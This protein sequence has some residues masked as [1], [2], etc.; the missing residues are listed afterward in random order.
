MAEP[1]IRRCKTCGNPL[2]SYQLN[3][4][5][6]TC[7]G[8]QRRVR[9][10]KTCVGCG[11][12]F[13]VKPGEAKRTGRPFCSRDCALKRE[14]PIEEKFWAKVQ[15]TETCWLWIGTCNN[16][17]YG[18]TRLHNRYCLAHRASYELAYGPFAARLDVRH[19]C[20][21]PPCVNPEHLE[22]GTHLENMRDSVE[23]GRNARGEKQGAA[24]MTEVKVREARAIFAQGGITCAEV[25]SRY[26]VCPQTMGH[27]LRRS[28]WRHVA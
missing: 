6:R 13:T 4:C 19:K 14:K 2:K 26:G 22:L 28:T 25:A 17:G 12:I 20:D 16:Q 11:N 5:G 9:V 24:K 3:A 8:A 1:I 15:K 10:E 27:I 7:Q 21:N 23:R 18:E